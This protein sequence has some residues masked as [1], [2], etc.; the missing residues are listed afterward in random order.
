LHKSISIVNGTK[1]KISKLEGS[2]NVKNKF[3][4]IIE[5]NVGF[6]KLN[7]ISEVI[8]GNFSTELDLE[9]H[10]ISKFKFAPITSSDVERVFW[11]YKYILSDR[12]QSLT[13]DNI[14]KYL[15]IYCFNRNSD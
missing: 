4:S 12:R 13:V 14:E 8:N 1:E 7:E 10:F 9:P 6:K 11:T 5:K 3:C 15:V 2:V